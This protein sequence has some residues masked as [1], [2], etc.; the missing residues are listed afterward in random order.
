[1]ALMRPTD[2]RL[3]FG[4]S[5]GVVA[6]GWA[7]ILIRLA[8][9]PPLSIAAYRMLFA[10]VPAASLA[11]LRHRRELRAIP[12]RDW[13]WLVGAGVAL[14]LHFATWIASLDL[15]TVASSVVLVTTQPI[16]VVLLGVLRLGERVRPAAIAAIAVALLG[17][18]IITGADVALGG[19]ALLGDGLAL[20]GAVGAAIYYAIGRRARAARSLVAYVGVVYS[21][22]AVVLLA[23]AV[24]SRQ[25]LGGFDGRT[26][27]YFGLLALAPQLIGHSL[28]NW[29]LRYL[30]AAAV[31]V[32][33]LGEPL[34]STALAV[35]ILGERPGLTALVGGT[36]TL[37]GVYLVL[38]AETRPAG[39]ETDPEAAPLVS[40]P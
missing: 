36:I 7:A 17:S 20:V 6:L 31:T 4:L 24:L 2:R 18:L 27:L 23:A 32:A 28:L 26:W 16:W 35:P 19:E 38:R 1:M 10:A 40:P 12:S 39:K 3:W 29:A 8:E 30:S 21:V 15:T 5:F 22:A 33:V 11:L 25:P 14:G 13:R 37:A 34:I 9:A